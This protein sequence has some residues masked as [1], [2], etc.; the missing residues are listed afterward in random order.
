MSEFIRWLR[1]LWLTS[2]QATQNVNYF[3]PRNLD[4]LPFRKF[5][6]TF[7]ETGTHIGESVQSALDAGFTTIKTVELYG[8]FY[9]HAVKRF[10]GNKNITCFHGKSVDCLPEMVKDIPV[11]SVFWLDA[12][13]SGPGTALH[14]ELMAG[15][16]EA[17]QDNILFAEL[18][19]IL[20]S[21]RHVILID[22]QSGWKTAEQFADYIDEYYP[23]SYIYTILD[24]MRP[25]VH[26]KEKILVCEPV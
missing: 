2:L 5:S 16:K 13:P 9:E 24:E 25:G 22:D 17:H 26:Y 10:E 6:D 11:P 21:G 12:H 4:F 15:N 1:D 3:K 18:S 7:I 14:D 20:R 19:I 23:D 8:Q